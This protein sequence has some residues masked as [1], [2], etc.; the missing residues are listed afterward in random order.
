MCDRCGRDYALNPDS[1]F[2][3]AC[4]LCGRWLRPVAARND[5]PQPRRWTQARISAVHVERVSLLVTLLL[6]WGWGWQMARPPLAS[7]PPVTHR[8]ARTASA[9]A[10]REA[11]RWDLLAWQAAA[12][13]Q[14]PDDV[15]RR[16]DLG[17]D[18]ASAAYLRRAQ[19][20]AQTAFEQARTS[21]ERYRATTWLARIEC[22]RGNH[23]AEFQHALL[24][25]RLQP[26]KAEAQQA[27]S[28]AAR[29]TGRLPAARKA[30]A[31]LLKLGAFSTSRCQPCVPRRMRSE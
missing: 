27:L 25:V 1:R 11:V 17:R 9:A 21:D 29:C 7:V 3:A 13:I 20:A 15:V 4:P 24:M 16:S 31:T 12:C 30:E 5:T 23:E 8:P 10:L 14:K 2:R 6:L 19:T 18:Q 22:Y 26:G 28:W